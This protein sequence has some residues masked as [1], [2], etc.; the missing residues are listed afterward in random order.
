MQLWLAHNLMVPFAVIRATFICVNE[1]HRPINNSLAGQKI[2][3]KIP[4]LLL[5]LHFVLLLHA[6]SLAR[7][8]LAVI[9]GQ[10]G[11]RALRGVQRPTRAASL[12]CVHGI[13]L[14][15]WLEGKWIAQ[16]VQSN[17]TDSII[18]HISRWANLTRVYVP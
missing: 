18:L 4:P 2:A 12:G 8:S 6:T 5:P 14:C 1:S 15:C 7:R 10:L 17:I 3:T 16:Q 9:H 11:I 13:L